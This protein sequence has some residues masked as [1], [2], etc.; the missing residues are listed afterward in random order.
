MIPSTIHQVWI[1]EELP[2]K[3]AANVAKI[4]ELNP[5]FEHRLWC[6]EDFLSEE[7]LEERAKI[8][9]E[10][11][12]SSGRRADRVYACNYLRYHI[13][14]TYGGWYLDVDFEP[15]QGLSVLHIPEG[16]SFVT[17]LVHPDFPI[18]FNNC[19]IACTPRHPICAAM[20]SALIDQPPGASVKLFNQIVSEMMDES[21]LCLNWR[22]FVPYD[23]KNITAKTI[24]MHT[25]D[26]NWDD[27]PQFVQNSISLENAR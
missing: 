4:R 23:K 1:G 21:T 22:Y 5:G 9:A 11:L 26:S 24:M 3:Y 7:K 17:T 16:I 13:L 19:L 20:Y 14:Q 8:R 6:L 15:Y 25:R 10:K 18:R 27:D 2:E 12:M